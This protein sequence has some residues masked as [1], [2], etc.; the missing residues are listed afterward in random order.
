[1]SSGDRIVTPAELREVH[2]IDY[3]AVHLRR[4][5]AKGLFPRRVKLGDGSPRC[6]HG[7]FLSEIEAYKAARLAQRQTQASAT[8]EAAHATA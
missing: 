4:L 7:W 6:R 1:M 5:E 2:G 3:T 8:Q